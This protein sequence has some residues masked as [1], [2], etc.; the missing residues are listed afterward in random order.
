[1][2]FKTARATQRNHA[3]KKQTNKQ[4]TNKEDYGGKKLKTQKKIILEGENV[5]CA[6]FTQ[7]KLWLKYTWPIGNGTLGGVALLE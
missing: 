4:K 2:S 5:N 7:V 1:M 6:I 3:S